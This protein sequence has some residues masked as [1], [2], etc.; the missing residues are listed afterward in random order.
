MV[1]ERRIDTL[2]VG[3]VA[4]VAEK[5]WEKRRATEGG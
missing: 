4:M 2:V 1:V 3:V 5:V